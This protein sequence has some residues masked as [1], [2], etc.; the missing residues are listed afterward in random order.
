MKSDQLLPNMIYLFD[1]EAPADALSKTDVLLHM[2]ILML[3]S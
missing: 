3:A 2:S 1:I